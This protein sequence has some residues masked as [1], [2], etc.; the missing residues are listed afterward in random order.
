MSLGRFVR[1]PRCRAWH[2]VA[3]DTGQRVEARCGAIS[4]ASGDTGRQW[5]GEVDIRLVCAPCRKAPPSVST[6]TSKDKE[7][8]HA[9]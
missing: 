6:D 8:D 3:A 4:I 5:R 1:W 2:I 9:K 7:N